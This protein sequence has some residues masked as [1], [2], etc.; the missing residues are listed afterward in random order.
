MKNNRLNFFLATS[1][2]AFVALVSACNESTRNA[3]G[4]IRDSSLLSD[5]VG[6]IAVNPLEHAADFPDAVLGIRSLTAEKL[7]S[8]SAKVIIKYDVKDFKLTEQT[9]HNHNMANSHEGQHIHFILNNEPYVALYKPEHTFHVALNEE[10]LLMSFLSRSFHESLKNESAY[11]LRKFRINSSGKVEEFPVDDG[12]P[13]LFYSRPKGEYK[14][15]ETEFVLLDFYLVNTHLTA[16]GTQIK[17]TI[18]GQD[19]MLSQWTPYEVLN[20]PKGENTFILTLV[21]GDG[22]PLPGNQVK[23]ERKITLLD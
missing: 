22:K 11:Q 3:D 21:D 4:D 10:Q 20:L 12:A 14:G 13:H 17:A 1:V 8:D 23:V 15:D 16:E 9:E 5:T 2:L 19:F 6:S 7:G 18:N